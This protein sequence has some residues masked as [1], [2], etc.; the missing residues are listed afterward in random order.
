MTWLARGWQVFPA[1]P[2]TRAWAAAALPAARAVLADPDQRARWLRHGATWFAGV[3]AL[4]NDAQGRVG[5]GPPLAGA[6]WDSVRDVAGALALHPAQLSVTFPGYP[7]QDAGE[8]AA[9]HRYR[10]I[11][12][13]AHLDGLL[14]EGPDRR[15]HLREP[16]GYILGVALTRADAGAA[17]LVVYEASHEVMRTA[18]RKALTGI[19]PADW[20]D[21]D[22]TEAYQAARARCFETCKRVTI[23]LAPGDAVVV[24]RLALH[25]IAP[26]GQNA[27]AVPEGRMIAYL[28]PIL[29]R[30][31]DWLDLP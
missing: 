1:D 2:A 30:V 5:Q 28:R 9:A 25:G 21:V 6:A 4:P 29:P 7:R 18:L 15:R 11:R 3:D 16:H 14:P 17:P 10:L 20:G 31:S 19:A 27:T 26:W 12:D 13:A 8:S 24:H 23:T 22:I